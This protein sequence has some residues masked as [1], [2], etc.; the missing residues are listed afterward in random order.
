[1]TNSERAPFMKEEHVL[2]IDGNKTTTVS[3]SRGRLLSTQSLYEYSTII[4]VVDGI[5]AELSGYQPQQRIM[6]EQTL[7]E[8]LSQIKK[9]VA[10]GHNFILV[11]PTA[12]AI[13]R[14]HSSGAMITAAVH[15]LRPV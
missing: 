4:W 11:G 2:V 3:L 15:E 13:H 7:N 6:L 12:L 5:A 8:R 10:D 14:Q 9:W 1:M